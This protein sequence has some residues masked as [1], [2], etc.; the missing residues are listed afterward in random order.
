LGCQLADPCWEGIAGRGLGLVAVARGDVVGATA[1]LLDT[2]QRCG[3][4]P[5]AYIWGSAYV[6]DAACTVAIETGDD[7]APAWADRLLAI[8]ARAGMRELVARS[9]W[10]RARLGQAGAA[11]SSRLLASEIGNPPLDVLLA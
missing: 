2:L 6:L 1:I 8:S 4:L 11:E 7:R 5:D 10:H 9:H 3:R